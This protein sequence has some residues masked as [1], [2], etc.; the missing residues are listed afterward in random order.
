MQT[1]AEDEKA[2]FRTMWNAGVSTADIGEAFS[3]SQRHVR[4]RAD[5]LRL[6]KRTKR[7]NFI[8][9]LPEGV[10]EQLV[11]MW[12][13]GKSVNEIADTLGM[14]RS[15]IRK[16]AEWLGLEA[17]PVPKKGTFVDLPQEEIYRRAA[18]IRA[19]RIKEREDVDGSNRSGRLRPVY[20]W[21]GDHF[22]ATMRFCVVLLCVCAAATADARPRRR[23]GGT[24]APVPAGH[25]N[26]TAQDVANACAAMGRLAHIGGNKGPEGLGMGPSRESAYR[27]CCFA[28]AGIPTVD[29]GYA[30][31]KNG[32]WCCCRR[33][34]R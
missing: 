22:A 7:Q 21:R 12:Q 3:L 34:R 2:K 25:S 31:M 27:N 32:Y 9:Q 13:A 19:K 23:S 8:K 29:V 30:Q 15:S 14:A 17:R 4:N 24:F 26:A 18:E 20:G 28:T 16:T 1:F 6:P 10:K 5:E 11:E 33:Y